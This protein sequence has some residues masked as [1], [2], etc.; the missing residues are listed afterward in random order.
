MQTDS[1]FIQTFGCQM[2]A[3]D[4]ERMA[5]LLTE[6]GFIESPDPEHAS[7]IIING[8]SVREKAVHKALSSLGRF[9]KDFQKGQKPALIGIGGCVG[10]LDKADL[11]QKAPFLD[12]VFGTDCI[13]NLPEIIYRAKSG[14]KH[15]L[16]TEFN[17]LM[18]YSTETKILHQKA[19]A[20]V[21]I[22]KGCDKYCTY[23][24]VP[25]TRGKEKSRTIHE[26]VQ[27]LQKL[28]NQGVTEVTLL[29]QNVNSFGKGN[30]NYDNQ[31]PTELH[32]VI[33]KVG[34]RPGEE[35]FPQLL[36]A[37][38]RDPL[39]SR[40]KRIRFT[41]SHPLDFS[42]ELI[43]CYQ[44]VKKLAS[45]L[46]LPVQS[47]SD[48]ILKKMG[49]HH[50]IDNYLSQMDLLRT[51]APEVG[52]TTDLIV[53]FPSETE[54]DFEET[55]ALLDRMQFDNVYAFCYSVRPGTRAAL[56][57]NDV[58][59]TV[60]NERL[61]RLLKKQLDISKTRYQSKVGQ[62]FEILVEG[63]SKNQLLAQ[64]KKGFVWTGRTSCNRVVNFFTDLPRN[65]TNQFVQ[66]HIIAA[67]A[68]ALQGEVIL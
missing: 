9:H 2:N 6:S 35:N 19:T 5:L 27:D 1:F 61:N 11:F 10:Q 22:M 26:V 48:R 49:R 43:E 30:I 62:K 7:V 20:Y 40:I 60:K 18:T 36:A 31:S 32:N 23:C 12:F 4:S 17:P 67:S 38:D 56:M 57:P 8:C 34:P 58:P 15:I 13:D 28:C 25:F 53:G 66:T 14:E 65:F 47:G 44:S 50:T 41:S 24:I 45:H 59:D 37:I 46:H 39:C 3:A 64:N 51:I 16:E 68:L 52:I 54:E 63:L 42:D 21:N 33:G 55:M 29:G